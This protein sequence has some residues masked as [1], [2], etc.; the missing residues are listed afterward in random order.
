M[1]SFGLDL[2]PGLR[3]PTLP[4]HVPVD[5]A[6]LKFVVLEARSENG[7]IHARTTQDPLHALRYLGVCRGRH[8]VECGEAP[9]RLCPEE[10]GAR[11][12]NR[13]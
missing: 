6:P 2:P 10:G 8:G 9:V 1:S 5:A 11:D 4:L 12:Q 13:G 7:R 3:V